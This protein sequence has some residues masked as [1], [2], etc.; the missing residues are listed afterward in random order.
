MKNR[1][2]KCI[3]IQYFNL[4]NHAEHVLI[5]K[6]FFCC[7]T[8]YGN[9]YKLWG[10]SNI[11]CLVSSL[12]NCFLFPFYV[13]SMIEYRKLYGQLKLS[14]LVSN[15][16]NSCQF[17][18]EL[19]SK[20]DTKEAFVF[21]SSLSLAACVVC[22]F[23]FYRQTKREKIERQSLEHGNGLIEILFNYKPYINNSI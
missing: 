13:L 3:R 1:T 20:Q 15:Q 17:G 7:H 18:L 23:S 16:E 9:L 12:L 19:V 6:L 4:F 2:I 10:S 14:C 8:G 21:F 11:L 5:F 22:V